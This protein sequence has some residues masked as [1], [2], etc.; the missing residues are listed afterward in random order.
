MTMASK[1]WRANH[2]LANLKFVVDTKL[3]FKIQG[4]TG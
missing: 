4:F 2:R 3:D 1:D